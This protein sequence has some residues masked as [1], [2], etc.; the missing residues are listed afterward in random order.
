MSRLLSAWL[1]SPH[2]GSRKGLS[3]VQVYRCFKIWSDTWW[4]AVPPL[5]TFLAS[6]VLAACVTARK[7]EYIIAILTESALL[8]VSGTSA[9][10]ATVA[11]SPQFII[12]RVTTGRSW[13]KGP[14]TEASVVSQAIVFAARSQVRGQLVGEDQEGQIELH[15]R[16]DGLDDVEA[17]IPLL[18]ALDVLTTVSFGNPLKEGGIGSTDRRHSR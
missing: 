9:G 2:S 5:L 13:M 12:F 16:G 14:L 17:G 10:I 11:I 15:S 3:V 6:I 4:A 7:L 8:P 18:P 1:V